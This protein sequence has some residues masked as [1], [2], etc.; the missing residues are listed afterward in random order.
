MKLLIEEC[1]NRFPDCL[2]ALEVRCFNTRAIR[3]YE[4]IGFEIKKKYCKDTLTGN[5]EFY[6]MENN[7]VNW[8]E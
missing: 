1:R 2:I 7:S 8:R 3:C 4:N 6:L 5:A